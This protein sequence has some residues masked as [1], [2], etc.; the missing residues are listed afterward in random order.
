MVRILVRALFLACRWPPSH[1]VL[2]G[3]ER[4]RERERER[5]KKR[6]KEREREREHTLVSS[7]SFRDSNLIM[8]ALPS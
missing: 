6:E 8:E 1:S 5:K 4:Q 2:Y 3:G 7:S